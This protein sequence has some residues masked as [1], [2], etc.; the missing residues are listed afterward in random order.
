MAAA[1]SEERTGGMTTPSRGA[2]MGAR[3]MALAPLPPALEVGCLRAA[4]RRWRRPDQTGAREGQPLPRRIGVLGRRTRA[5]WWPGGQADGLGA[6][7][8]CLL[9][10]GWIRG[11]YLRQTVTRPFR[12]RHDDLNCSSHRCIT[13]CD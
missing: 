8:P 4:F 1:G 13:I 9:L 10:A 3:P 6:A 5:R 12:P 2:A 7:G 11:P